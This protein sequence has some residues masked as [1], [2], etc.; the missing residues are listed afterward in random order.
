M[1][2]LDDKVAIVTG[3]AQG[4]GRAIAEGLAAEGARI[5]IADLRGAEEATASFPAG[6]G[7]TVDVADE[8]AVQRMADET[9]ERCGSID[10]LFNN[11]GLYASLEMRPFDQIRSRNGVRSWTSTWR[12]CSSR[13]GLSRR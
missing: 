6:V 10:V 13:A 7:L 12:R 11:A 1:G 5:V 8:A 9:V 3:G 4:I 2:Q